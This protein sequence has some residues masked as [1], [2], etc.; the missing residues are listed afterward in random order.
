[1]QILEFFHFLMLSPLH[2][3][4]HIYRTYIKW[5]H[6]YITLYMYGSQ[7]DLLHIASMQA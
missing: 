1:M 6:M 7:L 3:Y 5:Q 4:G 2:E